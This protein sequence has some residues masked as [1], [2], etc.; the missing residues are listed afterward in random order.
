VPACVCPLVNKAAKATTTQREPDSQRKNFN[1]K[2]P[3]KSKHSKDPACHRPASD[4][5]FYRSTK[6]TKYKRWNKICTTM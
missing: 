1:M 5:D 2:D 3:V 6:Q 4:A